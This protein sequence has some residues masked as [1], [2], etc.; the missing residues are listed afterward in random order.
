M[1]VA[2]ASAETVEEA[3]R[4]AVDAASRVRIVY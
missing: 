4:I 2:L 1:G 3:R